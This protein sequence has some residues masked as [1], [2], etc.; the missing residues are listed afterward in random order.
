M[1]KSLSIAQ[2]QHVNWVGNETNGGLGQRCGDF[3]PL[4]QKKNKEFLSIF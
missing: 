2:K 4:F 3:F 1:L